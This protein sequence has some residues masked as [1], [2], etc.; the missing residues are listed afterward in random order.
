MTLKRYL[1]D[2]K[3]CFD[4]FYLS[5]EINLRKPDKNIYEFVLTTTQC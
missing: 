2:L 5:Q 1:I 3:N 4:A